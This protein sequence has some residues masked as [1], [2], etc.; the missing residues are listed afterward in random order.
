MSEDFF[1]QIE[2]QKKLAVGD[3]EKV[4]RGLVVA[5]SN[6]RG[7]SLAGAASQACIA[8]ANIYGRYSGGDSKEFVLLLRWMAD[9]IEKPM[10]EPDDDHIEY[11]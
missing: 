2:A 1:D 9:E 11:D 10:T 3:F 7:L 5:V 6:Q 4:L 8:A